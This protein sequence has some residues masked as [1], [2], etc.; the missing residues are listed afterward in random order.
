MP[1]PLTRQISL[2]EHLSLL[3]AAGTCCLIGGVGRFGSVGERA[4]LRGLA[5]LTRHLLGG[6][7]P[8]AC[9]TNAAGHLRLHQALRLLLWLL[10]MGRDDLGRQNGRR[11]HRLRLCPMLRRG[12]AKGFTGGPG[13][14][15]RL[16]VAVVLELVH[17][18]GRAPIIFIILLMEVSLRSGRPTDLPL[19]L[20]ARGR[21]RIRGAI[22]PL[23]HTAARARSVVRLLHGW[24]VMAAISRW[25]LLMVQL[26]GRC[27][28]FLQALLLMGV[29]GGGAS[30]LRLT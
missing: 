14:G 1:Q 15:K 5:R 27:L 6:G 10:L 26:Q 13:P 9:C 12:Q 16:V 3:L 11:L 19:E 20:L 7:D 22:C 8:A 24:R 2:Q 28:Q 18:D 23:T 4:L 17:L 30:A 21:W 25:L 29:G